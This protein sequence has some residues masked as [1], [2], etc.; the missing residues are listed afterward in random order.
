MDSTT[1]TLELE[2]DGGDHGTTITVDHRAVMP[3]NPWRV[4]CMTLWNPQPSTEVVV[5]PTTPPSSPPHGLFNAATTAAGAQPRGLL[6][7]GACL[8]DVPYDLLNPRHSLNFVIEVC[9]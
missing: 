7:Q 3:I 5:D 8:P 2:D 9:K 6:S 4:I 1:Y